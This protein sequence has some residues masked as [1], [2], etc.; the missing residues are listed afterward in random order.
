MAEPTIDQLYH[1]FLESR[2]AHLDTKVVEEAMEN[3]V[4]YNTYHPH[5]D[6]L[7]DI[8]DGVVLKHFCYMT[9]TGVNS[10]GDNVTLGHLRNVMTKYVLGQ[11]VLDFDLRQIVDHGWENHALG[12]SGPREFVHDELRDFFEDWWRMRNEKSSTPDIRRSIE[13]YLDELATCW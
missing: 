9:T 13:E 5:D 7:Q 2:K 1:I 10:I 12:D 6:F 3:H 8:P 4:D 11:R